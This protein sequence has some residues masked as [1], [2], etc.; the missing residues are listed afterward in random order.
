MKKIGET[1]QKQVLLAGDVQAGDMIVT[2]HLPNA[3]GG[4]SVA[5][6]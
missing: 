5:V 3:I 2:T 4:L 6:K 1:E